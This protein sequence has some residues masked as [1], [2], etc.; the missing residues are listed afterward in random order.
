[1][2]V[3]QWLG[4]HRA[5][6]LLACLTATLIAT[7]PAFAGP[8]PLQERLRHR[9]EEV[10][11]PDA[12]VVD[13]YA[14]PAR[15][16]LSAFYRD[17]AY[18]PA[19]VVTPEGL[20]EG[21]R[22]LRVLTGARREGLV[23]A[24]YPLARLRRLL[25]EA[26]SGDAAPG[27]LVDLELLLTGSYL[28]YATHSRS[29]RL[30][31]ETLAVRRGPGADAE[32]VIAALGEALRRGRVADSLLGMAPES[33]YYRRLL[34]ALARYR[35]MRDAGGFTPVPEGPLL[36]PGDESQRLRALRE[37]LAQ[38]GDGPV[39]PAGSEPGR[40]DAAL[41]AAVERFQRRHGLEADGIIGPR[42]LQ[43]LN[44]PADARVRQIRINLERMRWLSGDL[45]ER[46]VFVNIAGFELV[47]VEDGEVRSRQRVIVGRDYRQTPVFTGRMTYLVFNPSWQ[48]PQSLSVRDILPEVRRD[49]EYLERMGFQVLRGWGADE[50]VIDPDTVDWQEV[51]TRG[52][53]YRFRQRP[54]PQNAL[55]RVKF[56]FPN[57]HAVYLHDTPARTLFNH[58]ERAFSSGCIRVERP[59]ELTR[60]LLDDERW[61]ADAIERTLDEGT[62]RTVPLGRA[63]PVHLQYLTAWV[64][65]DG[66]VN[67]RPDIYG[68]DARL[69]G[70]LLDTPLQP[71][72]EVPNL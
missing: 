37:R 25:G 12:L 58:A 46:Y 53:P 32:S 4:Y 34:G 60:L 1:M 19:W 33:G 29:G 57:R 67:L 8:G 20:A 23:L 61:D 36:R 68:R 21:R 13:G 64:G 47:L 6:L 70:A 31:S 55:G 5:A 16:A 63:V 7:S 9:I 66:V 15:D 45:G 10:S 27:A 18:R 56:M 39:G 22:L 65:S 44:T 40:Y 72:N 35:A 59:L 11:A 2:L 3:F 50:E 52:F 14:V 28:L 17:R 62:E 54:G 30:D 71:A 26:E 69:V 38:T 43:A 49:P 42:T 24:D 41:V 48:V 51:P